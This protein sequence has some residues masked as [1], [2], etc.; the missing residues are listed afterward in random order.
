MTDTRRQEYSGQN[1]L[2]AIK[3]AHDKIS[4]LE[5]MSIAQA[6]VS[7]EH[8]K[9]LKNFQN[10]IA[11][12]SL[13][14]RALQELSGFGTDTVRQKMDE[15]RVADFDQASKLADD[16]KGFE[17]SEGL[18]AELADE[19]AI[20]NLRFFGPESVELKDKEI[21]RARISLTH[22]SQFKFLVPTMLGMKVGE[23]KALEEGPIKMNVHLVGA[24]KKKQAQAQA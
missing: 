7:G 24:R 3:D 10:D 15:L 2:T 21:L 20:V 18:A 16:E 17:P 9:I 5:V 11:D 14:V 8:G 1:K 22:P 4:K 23:T 6:N 12:L 19:E 13:Q